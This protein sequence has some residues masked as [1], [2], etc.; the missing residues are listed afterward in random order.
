MCTPSDI[1]MAL[2]VLSNTYGPISGPK[3]PYLLKC[4]WYPMKVSNGCMYH[5]LHP[6]CVG[7]H[8][9]YPLGISVG[10]HEY[11]LEC[12]CW[13]HITWVR[14]ICWVTASQQ[15]SIHFMRYTQQI[16]GFH[17]CWVYLLGCMGFYRCMGLPFTSDTR[18]LR[19]CVD[20]ML[21]HACRARYEG[22]VV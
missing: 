20:G 22:G 12:I 13:V 1:P 6:I 5:G 9:I 8:V 7:L 4:I 17:I 14:Y 19:A 16:C 11:P 10:E 21:S 3:I 2:D 15:I 18:A